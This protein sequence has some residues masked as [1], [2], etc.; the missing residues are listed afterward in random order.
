MGNRPKAF[1]C[2]IAYC[3]SPITWLGL[4]SARHF[5]TWD[6]P[7]LFL[8]CFKALDRIHTVVQDSYEPAGHQYDFRSLAGPRPS[9][10]EAQAHHEDRERL[11]KLMHSSAHAYC[12]R[13]GGSRETFQRLVGILLLTKPPHDYWI[14]TEYTEEVGVSE[15]KT[16]QRPKLRWCAAQS[17]NP[18]DDIQSRYSTHNGRRNS[19]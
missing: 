13:C 16:R 6:T 5:D 11:S 1:Q 3:L 14:A 15:Q 7:Q 18:Y 12:R 10:D 2:P 4:Q 17:P 9:L 19:A 8:Y